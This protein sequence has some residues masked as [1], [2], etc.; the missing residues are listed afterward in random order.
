M[1]A[2]G[3]LLAMTHAC[4]PVSGE[5]GAR[6]LV[7]Y[8]VEG[9][10]PRE[11]DPALGLYTVSVDGHFLVRL[12]IDQA[13]SGGARGFVAL[14]V[15]HPRGDEYV[16][17][18]VRGHA[19]A[20]LHLRAGAAISARLLPADGEPSALPGCAR[21]QLSVELVMRKRKRAA[22][23]EEDEAD[24]RA[25]RIE[26]RAARATRRRASTAPGGARGA[27]GDSSSERTGSDTEWSDGF[28][29]DDEARRAARSAPR[30]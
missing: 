19:G 22:D 20:L 17:H 27:S 8:T 23:L 15:T 10:C 18:V 28:S 24:E 5:G 29:S 1:P 21:A 11:F 3:R 14:V 4:A 9:P 2:A 25:A 26:R 30:R 12:T 6:V 13:P 16:E 7:R